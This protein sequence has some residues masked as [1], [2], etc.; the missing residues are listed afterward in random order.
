VEL[1]QTIPELI[2]TYD[3]TTLQSLEDILTNMEA[4]AFRELHTVHSAKGLEAPVVMVLNDWFPNNQLTN[5]QYVAWTRAEDKL[6][7]VL[8]WFKEKERDSR[9]G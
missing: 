8:D 9:L 4:D 3:I 7:L 2:E 6:L 5:M 1:M